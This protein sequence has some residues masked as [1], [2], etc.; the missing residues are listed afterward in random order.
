MLK[1]NSPNLTADLPRR[2]V[3]IKDVASAAGVST[4][5][6]SHAL[7]LTGRI[8]AKTRQHVLTLARE[9]KYYPNRNASNLASRLS[10]TLGVIVSDIENPFFAVAV[11]SFEDTARQGR[12]ETIVSE[13]GYDLPLMQRAAENMLKQKVRGV[14][15]LTSE[16]SPRWLEEI[17][18]QDI[19]I[20]GFDLSIANDKVTNIRID[21]LSGVRKVVEHLYQLGHRRIGFVGGRV[22]FKNILSREQSYLASMK[23]LGLEPGPILN[24]NQRPDGGYA[25]GMALLETRPRPTAVVALNDLTAIGLIKAFRAGGLDVPGDISVTGFDNTYLAHYFS[26]RLTTVDMHPDI[27]GRSAAEALSDSFGDS[28]V[29]KE[30]TISLNLVIGGSTGPAP[31]SESCP[32]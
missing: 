31:Q 17:V 15:I 19:P 12:F 5:T 23:A 22:T 29:S 18:L 26:P 27:L 10:R 3:T 9:L 16:M 13:T 8:R 11:R 24:G 14:A 32:S 2:C 25:A 7:N 4:A 21:Y 1:P 30:R 28:G 20:V 6:V